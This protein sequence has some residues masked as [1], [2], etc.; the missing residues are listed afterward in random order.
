MSAEWQERT[1]ILLGEDALERLAVKK[2]SFSDW[3]ASE[4][5]S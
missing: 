2:L 3:A 4:V 1:A 5:T